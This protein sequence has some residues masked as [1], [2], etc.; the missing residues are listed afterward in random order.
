MFLYDT[1]IDDVDHYRYISANN[2]ALIRSEEIAD[3]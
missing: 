3:V 1:V 2:Y